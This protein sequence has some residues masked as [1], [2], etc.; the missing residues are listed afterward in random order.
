MLLALAV[1]L[2]VMPPWQG[3]SIAAAMSAVSGLQR[4]WVN[5]RIALRIHAGGIGDGRTMTT[6]ISVE[7]AKAIGLKQSKKMVGTSSHF[8][9]RCEA[10]FGLALACQESGQNHAVKFVSI[11]LPV[12]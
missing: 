10:S 3:V 9:A 11:V 8:L 4:N 6:R 2:Q 1:W 12:E 5:L 7:G